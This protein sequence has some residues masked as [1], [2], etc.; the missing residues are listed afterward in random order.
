MTITTTGGMD[1]TDAK[2]ELL[3]HE[4][5]TWQIAFHSLM[6]GGVQHLYAAKGADTAV[7]EMRERLGL[8]PV[9]KGEQA[10]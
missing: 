1:V 6:K 2:L 8:E 10:P 7:L 9:N 3:D 5:E 4:R